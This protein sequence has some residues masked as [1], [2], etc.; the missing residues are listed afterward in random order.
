VPSGTTE[1]D[2]PRERARRE[3]GREEGHGRGQQNPPTTVLSA[4]AHGYFVMPRWRHFTSIPGEE[5]FSR[6]YRLTDWL[7]Y[8]LEQDR[9]QLS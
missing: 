5:T 1:E 6:N 8:A 9:P 7:I 3:A 4:D 2:A